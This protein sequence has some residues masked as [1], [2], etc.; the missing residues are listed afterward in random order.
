MTLQGQTHGMVQDSQ[1]SAGTVPAASS[2]DPRHSQLPHNAHSYYPSHKPACESGDAV[3]AEAGPRSGSGR[4]MSV[5]SSVLHSVAISESDFHRMEWVEEDNEGNG[6]GNVR[7]CH[8]YDEGV[9]DCSTGGGSEYIGEVRRHSSLNAAAAAL[10]GVSARAVTLRGREEALGLPHLQPWRHSYSG[11]GAGAGAGSGTDSMDRHG[12]M[13]SAGAD[14]SRTERAAQLGDQM[15]G[16]KRVRCSD[17]ED[18]QL[19]KRHA[20]VAAAAAAAA[21][22]SLPASRPAVAA[23]AAAAAPTVTASMMT[24]DSG[25]CASEWDPDALQ[26]VAP[27]RARAMGEAAAAANGR[28]RGAD[29]AARPAPSSSVQQSRGE[30]GA[31]GMVRSSGVTGGSG[32]A[33]AAAA[34]GQDSETARRARA[35]EVHNQSERVR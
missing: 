22:S 16:L 15:G 7:Q 34:G 28:D 17:S 35:S 6:N 25:A 23:A 31:C 1:G 2:V 21:G 26:S 14:G 29:G 20:A 10:S 5:A 9:T 33:A 3:E 24:G 8:P 13:A 4:G 30:G 19:F 18:M 32:S 12:A 27:S 11:A